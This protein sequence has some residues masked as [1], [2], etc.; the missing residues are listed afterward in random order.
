[1]RKRRKSSR[2]S[3]KHSKRSNSKINSK[4]QQSYLSEDKKYPIDQPNHFDFSKGARR[5]NSRMPDLST[6]NLRESRLKGSPDKGRHYRLVR[7]M[8]NNSIIPDINVLALP[9]DKYVG[10]PSISMPRRGSSRASRRSSFMSHMVSPRHLLQK[11]IDKYGN[12]AKRN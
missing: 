4:L 3:S 12:Q 5:R 2:R 10:R 7:T 6:S 1:M 11:S 8:E 9:S